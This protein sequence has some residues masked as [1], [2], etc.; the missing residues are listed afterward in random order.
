MRAAKEKK[1]VHW[2]G[3]RA[4]TC[5]RPRAAPADDHFARRV[6]MDGQKQFLYE[7]MGY[8]AHWFWA[9]GTL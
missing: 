2:R 3:M 7:V 4:L 6:N 8:V 1:K 5:I 9:V